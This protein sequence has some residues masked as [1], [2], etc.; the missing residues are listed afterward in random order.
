MLLRVGSL[1]DDVEDYYYSFASDMAQ[2]SDLNSPEP[3]DKIKTEL[4]LKYL[5]I[6]L[7]IMN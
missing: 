2:N 6:F 3:C 1:L 4:C 7:L 5:S